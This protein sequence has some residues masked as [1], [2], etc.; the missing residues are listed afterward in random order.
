M[1][2]VRRLGMVFLVVAAGVC[3]GC[4]GG[5]G[6]R[7][8]PVSGRVTLDGQPLAD[9]AVYFHLRGEK[10]VGVGKT[11]PDGTFTLEN[12]ALPGK[13]M[14]ISPRPKARKRSTLPYWRPNKLLE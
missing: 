4:Q 1:R 5:S 8:V 3:F 12:G 6:P 2:S 7:P 10:H 14:C 11:K 9:V 13:T